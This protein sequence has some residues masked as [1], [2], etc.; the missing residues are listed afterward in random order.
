MAGINLIN[1]H[2]SQPILSH[3]YQTAFHGILT[4]CTTHH[5]IL[6]YFTTNLPVDEPM[7]H[8][9]HLGAQLLTL[10]ICLLKIPCNHA[11]QMTHLAISDFKHWFYDTEPLQLIPYQ[12]STQGK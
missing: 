4:A 10:Y 12:Y 8:L 7:D 9:P 1:A 3:D 5:P 6:I 2:S 11:L